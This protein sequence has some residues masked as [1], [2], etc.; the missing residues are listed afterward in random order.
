MHSHE[1]DTVGIERTHPRS[2][3]AEID[4]QN[5]RMMCRNLVGLERSIH[6][7]VEGPHYI[8]G[9]RPDNTGDRCTVV[10][11]HAEHRRCTVVATPAPPELLLLLLLPL[12]SFTRVG[13]SVSFS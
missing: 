9:R 6:K 10:A 7:L 4:R 13:H 12:W 1:M 5:N 8:R 2:M 11:R 3:Y